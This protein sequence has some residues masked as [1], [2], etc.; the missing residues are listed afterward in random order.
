[1]KKQKEE[2]EGNRCHLAY[3]KEKKKNESTKM[4]QKA[5]CRRRCQNSK[6]SVFFSLCTLLKLSDPKKL[7]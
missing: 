4:P 5:E 3:G 1:M 2:N 6:M 7:K